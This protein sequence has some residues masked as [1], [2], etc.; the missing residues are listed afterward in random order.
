MNLDEVPNA[1]RLVRKYLQEFQNVSVSIDSSVLHPDVK[2]VIQNQLEWLVGQK[3][4][5]P[6]VVYTMNDVLEKKKRTRNPPIV[7]EQVLKDLEM[8][9]N[10][11]SSSLSGLSKIAI[12]L[13]SPKL[14]AYKDR[15][16]SE[17][18]VVADCRCAILSAIG[19]INSHST[20]W[21]SIWNA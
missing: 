2:K 15:L 7:K 20:E 19:G 13:S 4:V 17:K 11:L 1:I 18:N 5:F 14:K 21:G 10:Y 3:G 16:L 9:L 12:L 6:V 8:C